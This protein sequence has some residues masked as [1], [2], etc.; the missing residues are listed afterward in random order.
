MG[1]SGCG[2]STVM[3]TLA[4]QLGWTTA[5][6][7][8]FHSPANVAKMRSGMALTDADRRP[9]LEALAA[10]IGQ[11]EMAGESAIVTCS[12]LRRS[13]RDFMRRGHESV[14]F[15][16]LVVPAA[17]LAAR[18]GRRQGHYMPASLLA[19]QLE[20]LEPLGPDEPG[21]MVDA[22][23]PVPEVVVEIEER[24]RLPGTARSNR[25]VPGLPE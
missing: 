23:R 19:S 20:T 14:R 13:Y 4:E 16:H 11:R 1:V 7:D 24:L 5:E 3:K 2:K 6:G 22:N 10:W 17:V 21:A 12:A 18:L 25:V 9:W 15:V 8:D